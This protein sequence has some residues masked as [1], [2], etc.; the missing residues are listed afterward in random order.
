MFFPTWF[1]GHCVMKQRYWQANIAD[2]L[3]WELS[4]SNVSVVDAKQTSD[5][6]AVI[7][8]RENIRFP[9]WYFNERS[10]FFEL[11]LD[12]EEKTIVSDRYVKDARR[13]PD[14][15]IQSYDLYYTDK[16]SRLNQ[17]RHVYWIYIP[18]KIIQIMKFSKFWI[19][20][21]YRIFKSLL[22]SRFNL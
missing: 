9:I 4:P 10:A 20:H 1:L 22:K 5:T 12:S 11:T 21:Q 17:V 3:H 16:K 2:A 14:P 8:F 7:R 6:T 19:T 13:S 18:V 15:Y